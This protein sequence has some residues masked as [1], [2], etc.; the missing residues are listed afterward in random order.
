M[1]EYP[2][3][4]S[5]TLKTAM[6]MPTNNQERW[7]AAITLL[8]LDV[9]A[10][11]YASLGLQVT[12]TKTW[13]KLLRDTILS[14]RRAFEVD[15]SRIPDLK[16]SLLSA[17]KHRLGPEAAS[18]LNHWIENVFVFSGEDFSRLSRWYM[19]LALSRTNPQRWGALG[20]PHGFSEEARTRL[21]EVFDRTRL[22]ALA[23]QIDKR[24]LSDWDLEMFSIHRFDDDDND[25]YNW[26]LETVKKRRFVS[27]LEWLV[28]SLSDEQLQR[29]ADSANRLKMEIETT[30][31]FPNFIDPRE[32]V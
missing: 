29:L 24:P 25:P 31:G 5:S 11:F 15:Q 19:L 3:E 2:R 6:R 22:H 18:R 1:A 14:N 7:G 17:L 21:E 28:K 20:L 12:D 23:D 30:Q 10:P 26:I 16:G 8:S 27:F 9:V 32:L 13:L 4:P